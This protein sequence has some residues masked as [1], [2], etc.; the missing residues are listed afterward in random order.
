MGER[1]QCAQCTG[2][3]FPCESNASDMPVYLALGSDEGHGAVP[4]GTDSANP[5]NP[6]PKFSQTNDKTPI[7]KEDK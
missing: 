1:N 7:T 4:N 5:L 6:P 2:L 3:I